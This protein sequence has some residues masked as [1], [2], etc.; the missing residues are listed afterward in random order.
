MSVYTLQTWNDI[1]P[2]TPSCNI[3]T[4]YLWMAAGYN[5]VPLVQ[6][7]LAYAK[8]S[9]YEIDIT[10]AVHL[11]CAYAQM[12]MLDIL[13]QYQSLTAHHI[14]TGLYS[15]ASGCQSGVLTY[16]FKK[17]NSLGNNF[18][19]QVNVAELMNVVCMPGSVSENQVLEC[20][21]I[22]EPLFGDL[23]FS[24]NVISLARFR[25]PIAAEYLLKYSEQDVLEQT[26]QDFE[27]SSPLQAQQIK[28]ILLRHKLNQ[29]VGEGTAPRSHKKM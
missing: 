17:A 4:E 6:S 27:Q 12:Q 15:A 11:S 1:L 23:E 22:F 13:D 16:L 14:M 26:A 7:V 29:A 25:H 24:N 18:Y 8:H 20:I 5:D 19:Q 28:D 9:N 21:K 3:V 2:T 10:H